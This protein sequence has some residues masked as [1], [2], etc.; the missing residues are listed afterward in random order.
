MLLYSRESRL[1]QHVAAY[2]N[3]R[4]RTHT[5]LD[6]YEEALK[7]NPYHFLLFRRTKAGEMIDAKIQLNKTLTMQPASL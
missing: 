3:Q 7:Q 5:A 6:L 1:Q 4:I 2:Y